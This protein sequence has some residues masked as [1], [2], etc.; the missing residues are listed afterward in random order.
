MRKL[1]EKVLE[2]HRKGRVVLSDHQVSGLRVRGGPRGWVFW[3]Q[4][5]ELVGKNGL[6][7]RSWTR[8]G[9]HSVVPGLG[10]SL[11]EARKRALSLQGK[12]PDGVP[13]SLT[14]RALVED[15]LAR[16]YPTNTVR[17]KKVAALLEAH[18]LPRIGGMPVGAVKREHCVQLVQ[19]SLV[20]RRVEAKG[21]VRRGGR[22]PAEALCRVLRQVFRDAVKTGRLETLAHSPAELLDPKDFGIPPARSR[23]RALSDEEMALLLTHPDLDLPGL[24]TGQPY[25]GLLSQSVRIAILLGPLLAV[26]PIA[27][28]GMRWDELDLQKA[29]WTIGGGRGAKLRHHLQADARPFVVPLPPTPLAVL[30]VL[31]QAPHGD[32]VL[33]A[34]QKKEGHISGDTYA[35]A[36]MRLTRKGGRLELPGGPVRPHDARRTFASTATRLG[37]ERYVVERCLQH[38]LGKVSDTYLVDDSLERR[39]A[40]HVLVDEHWAAVRAGKA[41]TV[42]ALRGGRG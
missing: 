6:V 11:A 27:M 32:F 12:G 35:D 28:L 8:L 4:E 39:R 14:V 17:R 30:E 5:P 40:A 24:L 29:T 1:T 10:L 18:A 19:A 9:L 16:R 2:A 23:S 21:S 7:Q 37:V 26:R 38:S 22:A 33:P 34:T 15:F 3:F 31:K 42:V 41:A 13:V 25:T 36:M 20:E